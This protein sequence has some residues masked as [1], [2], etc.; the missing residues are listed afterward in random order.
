MILHGS[1]ECKDGELHFQ[2]GDW[3]LAL[4]ACLLLQANENAEAP[5]C[6]GQA[7][8]YNHQKSTAL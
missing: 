6:D 2:M 5:W 3:P 7:L 8:M 4:M 1:E